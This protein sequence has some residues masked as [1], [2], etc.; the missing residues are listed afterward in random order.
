M[1]AKLSPSPFW[2]SSNITSVWYWRGLRGPLIGPQSC[3]ETLVSRTADVSFSVLGQSSTDVFQ[4]VPA[5][6]PSCAFQWVPA[7]LPSCA[8][9]MV[10]SNGS[11]TPYHLVPVVWGYRH[12]KIFSKSCWINQKSDCFTIFRLIWTKRTSV[13]L[14]INRKMV[15]TIWFRVWI[16][17]VSW[18]CST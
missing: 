9:C 11:L 6:L 13:W 1:R 15:N 17:S 5:S 3:R 12:R 14:Q 10:S 8:C 4:W 16:L 18:P 7:C 2:N